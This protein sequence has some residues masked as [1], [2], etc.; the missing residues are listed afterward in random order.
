MLRYRLNI[1]VSPETNLRSKWSFWFW[2]S[3]LFQV[4]YFST[5]T[6][7]SLSGVCLSLTRNR[8]LSGKQIIICSL[9]SLRKLMLGQFSLIPREEKSRCLSLPPDVRHLVYCITSSFLDRKLAHFNELQARK[10]QLIR[11][12]HSKNQREIE[13]W[14]F[15]FSP[16]YAPPDSQ[17]PVFIREKISHDFVYSIFFFTFCSRIQRRESESGKSPKGELKREKPRQLMPEPYTLCTSLGKKGKARTGRE[18]A[19]FPFNGIQ[20]NVDKA[21][22]MTCN[23]VHICFSR[24]SIK[25]CLSRIHFY[26]RVHEIHKND[27]AFPFIALTAPDL[28]YKEVEYI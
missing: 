6:I 9:L 16:L 2:G 14:H 5:Y 17:K 25:G 21:A 27:Q 10:A 22:E 26:E 3:Y 12:C 23:P 15:S 24:K 18:K 28:G 11:L 1:S 19:S 4:L 8:H 20:L 13:L 7:F